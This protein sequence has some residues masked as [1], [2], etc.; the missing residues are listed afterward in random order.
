VK[1]FIRNA[2]RGLGF[3]L[4]RAGFPEDMDPPFEAIEAACAPFTMTGR[5]RLYGL[6]KA[7][8]YVVAAAI[9]GAI[10]ECGVWRGGSCMAAAMTLQRL[11]AADRDLYLY[12][13]YAGMTQPGAF[14]LD[15][16]DR[17]ALATWERSQSGDV[18]RWCYASLAEVESN[19]A[20]TGYPPDHLHFV[21]G[22]LLGTLPS[23]APEG[24]AILRLDTDF[25]ESTKHALTHLFGRLSAG[26]VLIVDDMDPALHA[27][28]GYLE[29]LAAVRER[30]VHDPGLVAAEL[31][32][33]S[34]V[35]V[36]TKRA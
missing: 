23:T 26:G 9:P 36:A 2:L 35:V 31:D 29:P 6:Y 27:D 15:H 32:F 16:D 12:D 22:D 25:Y 8:E 19:L 21:K 33:A 14:D 3:E 13:T 20:S 4:V 1:D 7:V 30:L 11:G 10:V 24:I 28:D 5:E 17:N 18:N 34:G